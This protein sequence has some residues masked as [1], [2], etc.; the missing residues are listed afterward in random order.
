MPQVAIYLDKKTAARVEASAR[1]E[2]MPVSRW[3]RH[4]I[5]DGYRSVWPEGFFDRTFGSVR[6]ASFKR[7][8][9]Y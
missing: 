4:R 8:K 5:K 7:P 3:I 9:Q 2:K 1:R 6:D